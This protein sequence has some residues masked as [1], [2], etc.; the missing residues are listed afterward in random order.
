MRMPLRRQSRFSRSWNCWL[1]GMVLGM[2][3]LLSGSVSNSF[4]QV[5]A[6]SGDKPGISRWI[7]QLSS[8]K[9]AERE[10]A[11]NQLKVIGTAGIP[12]L[13]KAAQGSNP[14]VTARAIEVL[15]FFYDSPEVS[16]S[17]AA[18]RALEQLLNDGPPAAAQRTEQ[19]FAFELAPSRRRNA[20]AA[21]QEL[22]G[23][24]VPTP[25]LDSETNLP[26][27][28]NLEDADSIQHAIL[29]KNWKGNLSSMKYL[30]RLRP[31]LRI[32][33][34]TSDAPVKPGDLELYKNALPQMVVEPRGGYLGISS[35]TSLNPEQ[36]EVDRIA[37]NSPAQ[38]AGLKARDRLIHIDGLPIRGFISLTTSLL[39][40]KSGETVLL[41]VLRES[42]EPGIEYDELEISVTLGEW[43]MPAKPA[44]VPKPG[45]SGKPNPTRP[46]SERPT[47]PDLPLNPMPR[48]SKSGSNPR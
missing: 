42:D 15:S 17:L 48:P 25:F 47:A 19:A 43:G 27:E 28:Q 6:E 5:V 30:E 24:L 4:A 7:Q 10:A 31:E 37:S 18:D 14:E 12:E 21:I 22:G 13:I 8:P 41:D 20:I 29:G 39:K 16:V 33:Y 1:P 36:C 26:A 44:A 9:F 35:G 46:T 11:S 32:V 3:W 34:I 45:A 23:I 2:F 38:H 40:R